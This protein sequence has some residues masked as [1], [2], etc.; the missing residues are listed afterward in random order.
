MQQVL[1]VELNEVNFE[2]L[3]A[4]I[5]LGKLPNFRTLIEEHGVTETTSEAQY[6]D[7][8]PWIQWVTAHTGKS[9]EEHRVFRLGDI[10][11]KDLE[12]IWERLESRFGLRVGA[13]SP[14]NAKNQS[15]RPAFFVPDPW[16]NTPVTAGSVV[17][18]LFQAVRQVV[19]DNA[20][21]QIKLSS[22]FWLAIG[23]AS[24]SGP[25]DYLQYGR[26]MA[27]VRRRKWIKAL[28]LDKLLSNLFIQQVKRHQPDF[29][30]LFLNGA[31]HIQHHYMFNSAVYR[32]RPSNPDWY[33]DS[34]EDP[35]LEVYELYDTVIGRM[36]AA[37]PEARLMIA[38]GLHQDPH[39]NLTY[40]WRLREHDAYLKKIGVPFEAVEP[41]MS[42][43]FLIRCESEDQATRAE[44]V[45]RSATAADGDELFSVDNR[46]TDLFV[47][48]EYAKDIDR[49][50][51]YTVDGNRHEGLANDV[52]FVALKNG[53]HNGIGYLMDTGIPRRD[54][55]PTMPLA[56]LFNY[57]QEVYSV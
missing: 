19:N 28:V 18:N 22:L 38:T 41:R 25:A 31:A 26:W 1:V 4:Y 13:I 52:A 34:G 21:A 35:V 55:P 40:Y 46:G 56:G 30:T 57:I 51:S 43:D 54:A 32:G 29:A 2:F 8:E 45:L 6:E 16:T 5:K 44:A 50:F 36:L 24:V 27:G 7:I 3:D 39:A 9:L 14:M 37:F 20:S 53:Q 15:D 17:T 47:M 23:A 11:T 49:G 42:R 33:V 10:E 48:L 12:Q